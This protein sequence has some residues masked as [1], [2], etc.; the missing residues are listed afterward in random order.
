MSNEVI[1][2]ERIQLKDY[3]IGVKC[4]ANCDIKKIKSILKSNKMSHVKI[5][6]SSGL[7]DLNLKLKC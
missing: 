7:L 5:Y 4:S 2:V 1:F 3:L 6:K